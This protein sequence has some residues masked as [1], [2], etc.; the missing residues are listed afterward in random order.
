MTVIVAD[1][2]LDRAQ[3]IAGEIRANNLKA[4]AVTCVFGPINAAMEQRT[5]AILQEHCPGLPV[6][7]SSA[8]YGWGYAMTPATVPVSPW[9]EVLSEV[10]SMPMAAAPRSHAAR[11][12]P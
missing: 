1:V 4:A 8:A 12:S 7:M 5:K 10:I 2:D 11:R 6:V 3:A 9:L